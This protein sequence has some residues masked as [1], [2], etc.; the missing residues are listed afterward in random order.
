MESAEVVLQFVAAIN[1]ADVDRLAALMTEDH[2][3]VD[4]DGSKTTGRDR[5]REAW[6]RYFSMMRDHRI[7]VEETFSSGNTVAVIGLATGSCATA[8]RPSTV[9]RWS[10]PAAWRAVVE[11]GRIATWQVFVNPEPILAAMRG[12]AGEAS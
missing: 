6:S 1:E 9:R 10:V 3:F 7:N 11:R 8:G 5:M 4:S 12:P 2:V